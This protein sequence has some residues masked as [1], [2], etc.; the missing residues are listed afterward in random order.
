MK[1]ILTFFC[2]FSLSQALAQTSLS[3]TS[4][5]CI[6]PNNVTGIVS[7]FPIL[8]LKSEV[9]TP[10]AINFVSAADYNNSTGK[11]FS[12][13]IRLSVVS[14]L[15]WTIS[16]QSLSSNFTN[17][18]NSVIVPVSIMSLMAHNTTNSF[19][20]I[21][22]NTSLQTLLYSTSTSIST[23]HYVDVNV[24]PGWKY[25]GGHYTT[26]LQFTISQQ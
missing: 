1:N 26:T 3:A 12:N 25:S 2:V 5:P 17:L 15:P 8:S 18:T 19:Q 10:N 11:N 9:L 13:Y 16:V 6:D 7:F 14:T 20:R 22:T 23:V 4:N 21:N 24:N